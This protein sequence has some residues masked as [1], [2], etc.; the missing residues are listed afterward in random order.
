MQNN[1]QTCDFGEKLRDAHIK[2]TG[3]CNIQVCL[4]EFQLKQ[5]EY[6][7]ANGQDFVRI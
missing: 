2:I 3:F 5:I 7:F 4:N 1:R 6:N